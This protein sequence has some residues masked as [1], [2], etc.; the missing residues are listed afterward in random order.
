MNI[1]RIIDVA[2]TKLNEEKEKEKKKEKKKKITS[3]VGRGNIKTYIR[4]GKARA[5]NDPEGLMKDLGIPIDYG[6]SPALDGLDP[7]EKIVALVRKSFE[8]A[9]MSVPFVGVKYTSGDAA[10]ITVDSN[11]ISLRDGTMIIN[12]LL[13]AGQNADTISVDE[14]IEIRQSGSSIIEIIFIPS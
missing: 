9:V 4:A 6:K 5:E 7:R 12:N 8:N 14:D 3:K 11:L 13:K 1:E 2:I 10:Q